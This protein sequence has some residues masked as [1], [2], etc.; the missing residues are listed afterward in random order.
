M[1]IL[2]KVKG[3]AARVPEDLSVLGTEE[4]TKNALVM[5]F[6]SALGY[7][8]FDPLEVVPEFTAD[9]GTKK[10]EKVDYAI[11]CG[12]QVNILI[13][14]KRASEKL[15]D[16][17]L[18]QLFRYFTVTNARIAVLTNGVVYRFFSDLEEPNKM[19]RIPFLEID[20]RQ[21]KQAL[22]EE[23]AKLSKGAF[24]LED[25]LSTAGDLKFTGFIRRTLEKQFEEP[26]EEFVKFFFGAAM[27]GG[28]FTKNAREHFSRLVIKALHMTVADRVSLRLHAALEAQEPDPE[29]D[30]IDEPTEA[31]AKRGTDIETTEEELEGYRIVKAIVCGVAPT[32]QIAWR[33]SKSYFGVLFDN[34]NRKP[35]CRLWFN[36]SKR[37][38]GL[39]DANKV[40]TKHL[41][42][43]LEDLYLYSEQLRGTVGRYVNRPDTPAPPV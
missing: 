34:N 14:A 41:I 6:I 42:E 22:L 3:L 40:E 39:F 2:E 8:V 10:G 31:E 43:S 11:M 16:E 9:V 30:A 5:P 20:L 27:P 19:D 29:A 28:R 23:V 7:D 17:H 24:D 35:I 21:P 32:H 26:D 13:E 4:A 18:S 15:S 38:L 1:S 25:M 37:Y 12:D 33:D 36:R